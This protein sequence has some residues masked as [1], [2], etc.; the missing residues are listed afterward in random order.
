MAQNLIGD[1]LK[2]FATPWSAPGWMKVVGTMYG[3]GPLK[4]SIDGP[5]FQAWANYFVK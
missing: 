5:Y 4:G 3:G 1:Q 2:L